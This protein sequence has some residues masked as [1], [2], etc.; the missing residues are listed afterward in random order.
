VPLRQVCPCRE[1]PEAIRDQALG[2]ELVAKWKRGQAEE[3]AGALVENV[4]VEFDE[5]DIRSM[6]DP[7]LFSYLENLGYEWADGSWSRIGELP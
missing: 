5:L 7:I 3:L 6:A 1:T 2:A 4:D